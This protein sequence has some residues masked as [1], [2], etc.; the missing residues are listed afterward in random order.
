VRTIKVWFC[1]GLYLAAYTLLAPLI[2]LR[3]LAWGRPLGSF[4][5]RFLGLTPRV[6]SGHHCIWL[7]AVSVGEV[8]LLEPLLRRLQQDY[9][10]S[11]FVIST[12]TATGMQLARQKYAGTR[13]FWFPVDFSWAVRNALRRLN[14]DLVLLAE[15]EVWPNLI[16]MARRQNIPVIVV[17]GRLSDSSFRGYQRVRWL[18]RPVFAGLHHVIAQTDEYADRFIQLGCPP[19]R[20][21]VA[22]SIKFDGASAPADSGQI[23]QLRHLAGLQDGDSLWVAGST[24]APEELMVTRI[25]QRL[26]SQHPQLRLVIVPRHPHR[27]AAIASQLDS[28]GVSVRLRSRGDQPLQDRQ[29]VLVADTIGELRS[30]W[31]L[32][33]VAFVGGSFGDRGGQN[34][35]EPAASGAAVCF[36]PNTW[37]FRHAVQLMLSH[38]AAREV[39]SESE[40]ET[41][42]G[43]C[44]QDP[45]LARR[46][47][48]AA[49]QLI[50]SSQGAVE[51]TC[52]LLREHTGRPVAADKAD[53]RAA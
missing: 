51:T 46:R 14:P 3:R 44:V 2:L 13:C 53:I 23:A 37:N 6:H 50:E 30:W 35:L 34:M 19:A 11:R 18:L 9:P 24:Q 15:L 41:F 31:R 28:L 7:H 5:Q 8:N 40:L 45:Q 49:R 12:T 22:G 20:V 42:V 4:R 52:R 25:W 43:E 17:N 32:A 21:S 48:E 47:G 27:G 39:R 10:G 16:E 36:G 26:A 29:Q 1:N 33:S 38:E